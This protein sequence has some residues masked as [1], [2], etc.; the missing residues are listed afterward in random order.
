MAGLASEIKAFNTWAAIPDVA[1][2]TNT[3]KLRKRFLNKSKIRHIIIVK[4]PLPIK[5]TPIKK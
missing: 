2:L 1:K 4:K 3:I 5:V